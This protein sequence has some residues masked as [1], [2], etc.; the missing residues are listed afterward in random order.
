MT[1]LCSDPPIIHR[2]SKSSR[3]LGSSST[4]RFSEGESRISVRQKSRNYRP[5]NRYNVIGGIKIDIIDLDEENRREDN[6]LI[7]CDS[8]LKNSGK[9]IESPAS[10]ADA[11]ELDAIVKPAKVKLPKIDP[12]RCSFLNN[13][14]KNVQVNERV[15]DIITNDR[16]VEKLRPL[17]IEDPD[18]MLEFLENYLGIKKRPM[19]WFPARQ[20]RNL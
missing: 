16:T 19:G 1:I 5:S 8:C 11:D 13:S 6:Q 7:L 14:R 2:S 12:K 3:I 18:R 17:R 15:F 20:T 9:N 10:L 4:G